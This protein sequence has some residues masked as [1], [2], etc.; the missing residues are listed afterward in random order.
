MNVPALSDIRRIFRSD[1]GKDTSKRITIEGFQRAGVLVPILHEAGG[2]R[3]L[4]TKR[5]E[6]VETHKGQISFPGGMVDAADKNIVDTALREVYEEVGIPRSSIE[7]LGTLDDHPTPTGFIIT[8]VIGIIENPPSL[9]PNME[10][11][12]E[13]L[14]VPLDIFLNGKNARTELREWRGKHHEVWFYEFGEHLIW[15]ATAGIVR[16]LLK[17]LQLL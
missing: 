1:E 14:F 10:E 3:L 15:G 2:V 12:A 4:L 16:A 13:I 7:T 11:V 5:T 9:L 17:K 8:P 6:Q